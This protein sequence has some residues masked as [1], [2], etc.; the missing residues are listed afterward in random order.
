MQSNNPVSAARR[1]STGRRTPYGNQIYAGSGVPSR[2]RPITDP[3]H[4]PARRGQRSAPATTGRPMT[5]DSVVQKTAIALGLVIVAAAATWIITPDITDD[6]TTRPRPAL[7]PVTI[8]R[9]GAFGLSMV[10]SFKRVISPALVLPSRPRGRGPRAL[11]QVLRR[12]FVTGH[13]LRRGDR[14]VRRVRRH[15]R[16]VQGSSTSRSARGSASSS[17]PRCSAWSA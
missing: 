4:G 12:S 5:I 7:R 16:G 15:P 9:L 8:G 10:N 2:L 17:S 3:S 1:G 11:Q 13:R 6:P 14:H